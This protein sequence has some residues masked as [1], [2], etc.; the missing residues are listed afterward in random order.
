MFG[1]TNIFDRY[2]LYSLVHSFYSKIYKLCVNRKLFI[3]IKI[4]VFVGSFTSVC[5]LICIR[6]KLLFKINV[7]NYWKKSNNKW[8][9][10]RF[11]I[12]SPIARTR[13][14]YYNICFA[15][16]CSARHRFNETIHTSGQFGERTIRNF[17]LYKC[18]RNRT[19]S[20]SPIRTFP[21]IREQTR[22]LS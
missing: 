12:L 16:S 21:L 20:T 4:T 7:Y 5:E 17:F 11:I 8:K 19:S 22:E 15:R 3:I 18:S 10:L 2:F 1:K 14:E 6:T 9:A 13:F